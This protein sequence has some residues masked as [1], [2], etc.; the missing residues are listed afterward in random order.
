MSMPEKDILISR[1]VDGVAGAGDWVELDMIGAADSSL[2]REL[3]QAQRDK[4]LLDGAVGEA[5]S[6]ADMVDLP[7]N[8]WQARRL[9]VPQWAGWATAAVLALAMFVMPRTKSTDV[10][11]N[12]AGL[13][14]PMTAEEQS[15]DAALNSYLAKGKD[16]GRVIRQLPEFVVLES[17]PAA[18]GRGYDV[19]YLRQIVERARVESVNSYQ[20]DDAGRKLPLPVKV[21]EPKKPV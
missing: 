20:V 8:E 11:M 5:I 2:W 3:A 7:R 17:K 13:V 21:I 18:D 19:V 4:Q 10:G 6:I 12:T 9:S 14:S 15:P 16:E 1:V